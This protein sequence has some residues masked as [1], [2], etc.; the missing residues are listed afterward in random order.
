MT[1]CPNDM[2]Q[3]LSKKFVL[4]DTLLKSKNYWTTLGIDF[5]TK[6]SQ[7]KHDPKPCK[8]YLILLSS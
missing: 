5:K 3:T 6:L 4:P 1:L 7:K 2:N 8:P